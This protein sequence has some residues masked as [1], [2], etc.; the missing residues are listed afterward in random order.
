MY[1]LAFVLFCA[2]LNPVRAFTVRN[3]V[4][5]F[6]NSTAYIYIEESD[7]YEDVILELPFDSKYQSG[8]EVTNF[9]NP[10][11]SS[12]ELVSA[13][14]SLL[15]VCP[16]SMS[17]DGIN[18]DIIVLYSFNS[19]GRSWHTL[20]TDKTIPLFT[21]SSYMN[22]FDDPTSLYIFG[23]YD[24]YTQEVS[25][26]TLKIDLTHL[27]VSNFSTTIQPSSFY[28]ASS[29]PI[30]YNTEL[31]IG[32]KV[33]DGW[34]SL[35]QMALWQYEAWAFKS[36][37]KASTKS[38][39]P[40]LYPLTLPLFGKGNFVS[41]FESNNFTGFD[42][43]SVLIIG[44]ELLNGYSNPQFAMLNTTSSTWSWESLDD[45]ISIANS[46]MNSKYD[47]NLS[48][49]DIMGAAVIYDTLIVISNSSGADVKTT[50]S[51][52]KRSYSYYMK[53]YNTTTFEIIDKIDYTD[54]DQSETHTIEKVSNKDTIIALSTVIPV[55]SIIIAVVGG[56]LVRKKYKKRKE[57]K[58]NEREMRE[59]ME[60]YKAP[61]QDGSYSTFGSGSSTDVSE[62][63]TSSRFSNCNGTE[64]LVNNYDDG[65][66]LS[67]S[68]WKRK[69]EMY[70][71]QKK[72]K[73][74]QSISHKS[75][76]KSNTNEADE[77]YLKSEEGSLVR[78]L[79]TLSSR[80]G[81][82]LRRTFSYQS[83]IRSYSINQNGSNYQT[84]DDDIS[85]ENS[86]IKRPTS[87]YSGRYVLKK[88][89]ST[90]YRI[91]ENSSVSG[92]HRSFIGQRESL[93][94]HSSETLNEGKISPERSVLSGSTKSMSSPSSSPS[95]H[96]SVHTEST[97]SASVLSSLKLNSATIIPPPNSSYVPPFGEDEEPDENL[98][99]QILV[100]SK[101]RSKLHVTNPDLE[102]ERSLRSV[103]R[104]AG[105]SP[106]ERDVEKASDRSVSDSSNTRR[107]CV[108]QESKE[109]EQD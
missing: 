29:V 69:R 37:S 89:N 60:F 41:A 10:P 81:R 36:V 58:E 66:N 74:L 109:E 92:H 15:A 105:N 96:T 65:D 67:I 78:R 1:I 18:K 68:S 50:S 26:R 30:D 59:I 43:S 90:L 27:T 25:N 24:N 107:R 12:C 22:T 100:S 99:V 87:T 84:E 56:I 11:S 32:G 53:L 38:I 80:L 21:G 5:N 57:E 52:Q 93:Y 76:I 86:T 8:E 4:Y 108:S 75:C 82:S 71:R 16:S 103:A 42:V 13:N 40:R 31:L 83:S 48:L 45:S 7:T 79:S 20:E 19:T 54:L 106:I 9:F 64:V 97:P 39:N 3:A 47:D 101:R 33:D 28:G 104:S 2:L 62:K 23:G 95:M 70:E 34:I 91:P 44:G 72:G 88:S 49:D 77:E 55:L 17:E 94:F 61:G 73:L 63:P 85:P 51:K 6:R 14:N 102:R 35:S 46:K 98:D